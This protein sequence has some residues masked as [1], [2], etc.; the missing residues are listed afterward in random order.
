MLYPFFVPVSY[1][2]EAH[3]ARRTLHVFSC[4]LCLSIMRHDAIYMF[5]L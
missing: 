5:F 1:I 4:K 3:A 2:D